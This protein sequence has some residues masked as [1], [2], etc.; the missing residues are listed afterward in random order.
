MPPLFQW[1]RQ[2]PPST[3]TRADHEFRR[4]VARVLLLLA[5]LLVAGTGGYMLIEGWRPLDAAYMTVI[6]LSTVGFN[7]VHPLS[8]AGHL[9]TIALIT[10]GV[11]TAAYAAGTIGE[12]VIGGR[13]GGSLRRQRM[14]HEIDR[15]E[16][17]Y[18]VCGYGRVGRQVVDELA[19]RDMRAVVVEP[20]DDAFPPDAAGPLRIRGDATDDRALRQAGIERAAG[21]VAVAGDDATNI[22]VTLSARALNSDLLIVARAIEAEAEDKLRRA[23]ATHVISPYRIGGQR[24]VTQLLHPRITDFL[25]VVVHRGSPELW[26][27]E[28]TV[29]PDGP[30][31]G[32]PLGETAIW[33]PDGV[34]VLAV[35]H[36]NGGL[37]TSPR[38]DLRLAAGDVLIALG[39][40]EQLEAARQAAGDREGTTPAPAGRGLRSRSRG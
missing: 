23:G 9:F 36:Q 38:K 1:P 3:G 37:V 8:D 7:E 14:Q 13:L 4:R 26:L 21:L 28:I 34:N 2:A 33:D 24:I 16:R 39:T 10:T 40:L 25:D 5:V 20:S 29:A 18:I 22:V 27:E 6:T 32:Q 35:A 30:A 19:A 12:Y 11:S 15:L 31:N 17:H